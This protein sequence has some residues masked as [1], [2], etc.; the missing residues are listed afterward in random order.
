MTKSIFILS[1]ITTLILFKSTVYASGRG[2]NIPIIFGNIDYDLYESNINYMGIGYIYDSN[3]KGSN[4][5]NYRLNINFEYFQHEYH[6]D[7]FDEFDPITQTMIYVPRSG[8]HKR[9]RFLSDHI[10]GFSIYN[11]SVFKYWL[12]P[13]LRLGLIGVEDLGVSMGIGI[14]AAGMNF[15]LGSKFTIGIEIGYMYDRD[16]FFHSIRSITYYDGIKHYDKKIDSADNHLFILKFSL[17]SLK[18]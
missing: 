13:M 8:V 3:L 15:N 11:N 6:Y 16:M 1:I 17:F 10:F 9:A 12:G 14:T 5:F 7:Q 2:F 18:P 4:K